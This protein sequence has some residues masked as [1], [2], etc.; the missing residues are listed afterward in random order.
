MLSTNNGFLSGCGCNSVSL[1]GE[2]EITQ[3]LLNVANQAFSK[4]DCNEMLD[5]AAKALKSAV[6][7]QYCHL[8]ADV[9][10]WPGQWNQG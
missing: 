6:V 10:H 2:K 3:T 4:L 8:L 7:E 5:S 1:K 9:I